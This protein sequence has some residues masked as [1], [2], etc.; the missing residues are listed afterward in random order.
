M[1]ALA[2]ML[3]LD[4][5]TFP[6]EGFCMTLAKKNK[7]E[8]CFNQTIG[9]YFMYP[10]CDSTYIWILINNYFKRGNCDWY[11]IFCPIN[12]ILYEKNSTSF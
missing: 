8:I 9:R 5:V 12:W 11:A 3:V 4:V 2:A 7:M 10:S 6:L 1:G